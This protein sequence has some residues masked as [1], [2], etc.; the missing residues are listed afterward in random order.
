MR[1]DAPIYSQVRRFCPDRR[2]F[3]SWPEIRAESQVD[4][5]LLL[6]SKPSRNSSRVEPDA[7]V[8]SLFPSSYPTRS[9]EC[10]PHGDS[11]G[12]SARI[13]PLGAVPHLSVISRLTKT[14][15]SP[16]RTALLGC[17]GSPGSTA[18]CTTL[19]CSWA[20]S[21]GSVCQRH[22]RFVGVISATASSRSNG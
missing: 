5:I 8:N 17:L 20:C 12:D 19:P 16:A 1:K 4:V 6:S 10:H 18:R 9:T 13:L 3:G 14:G 11:L 2:Q 22:W 7:K 21:M 15:A